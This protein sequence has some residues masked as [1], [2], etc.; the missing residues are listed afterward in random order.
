MAA[1]DPAPDSIAAIVT[2]G[3]FAS[4]SWSLLIAAIAAAGALH[5]VMA[6]SASRAAV[7]AVQMEAPRRAVLTVEHVVELAPA[8]EL[9]RPAPRAEPS[10]RPKLA[11][12]KPIDAASESPSDSAAVPELAQAGAVLTAEAPAELLDFTGMDIAS[13]EASHFAG[14]VTAPS[15]TSAEPVRGGAVDPAFAAGAARPGRARPV[16]LPAKQ[17]RCP[18]PSEAEQLGIDEQLVVLRVVVTAEGRVSAAEVVSDPGHGFG[19]AALACARTA[20]FVPAR[21]AA[22]RAYAATSPPIRVR[23]SR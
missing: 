14:G 19:A 22:G 12:A 5:A 17:W 15:G 2:S 18:W 1:H 10:P 23:F 9:E 11:R 7:R 20:R 8:P 13:G 3:R 6:A 21:D 4:G 16:T